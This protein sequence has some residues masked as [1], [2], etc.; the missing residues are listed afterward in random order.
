MK[1]ILLLLLFFTAFKSYALTEFYISVRI[2]Q[3]V[4]KVKFI[5]FYV[6]NNEDTLFADIADNVRNN[7]SF[8][9]TN[10]VKVKKGKLSFHI[11]F[12][13]NGKQWQED[14]Y[15]LDV[16]GKERDIHIYSVFGKGN[17]G[18][19]YVDEIT[20]YRVKPDPGKNKIIFRVPENPY[21]SS[22]FFQNN[23]DTTIEILGNKDYYYGELYKKDESNI[24]DLEWNGLNLDNNCKKQIETAPVTKGE[25][26]EIFVPNLEC[27]M[28]NV[29]TA[30]QYQLRVWWAYM[31][32]QS[33]MAND[34]K[35]ND[36]LVLQR[37]VIDA[38]ELSLEFSRK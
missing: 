38:F 4:E 34:Q 10:E 13:K 8:S 18:K 31:P 21:D 9:F 23:S 1:K 27:K 36:G 15:D 14:K 17:D 16:T 12:S 11:F 25:F 37:H 3:E 35:N 2:P 28:L 7:Y 20:V 26:A 6:G 19:S 22:L 24:F 32:P 30:G 5:K 33:Q 29:K